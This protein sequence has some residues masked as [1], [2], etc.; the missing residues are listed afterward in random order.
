M[1]QLRRKFNVTLGK[2]LSPEASTTSDVRLK[3]ICA[4]DVHFEGVDLSD[5]KEMW[6]APEEI[7]QYQ[8]RDG[9]LLIVEGGA[10]AGNSAIVNGI[11]N[12]VICVQI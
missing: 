9:D 2:M 7:R 10:G 3:Y 5:L 1:V 12:Q 4:K 11:G 8:V 6:Y